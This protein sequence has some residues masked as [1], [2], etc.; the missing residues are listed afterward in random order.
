MRIDFEKAR[1]GMVRE[2]K[3]YVLVF[4]YL[5]LCIGAITVFKSLTLREYGIDYLPLGFAFF[6]ALILAKFIVTGHMLRLG[7]RLDHKPLIYST[8]YK[9]LIFFVLLLALS[10]AEEAIEGVLH[11][12]V[13]TQAVLGVGGGTLPGLL[14][15]SVIA[16]LILLPYIA[17]RQ[18][19]EVLGQG[20]LFYLFF[21]SGA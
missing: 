21:R 18:L 14:A 15:S 13:L 10:V 8:L 1:Q 19:D 16:L 3:E 5:Y 17:L 11:G 6:K 20:R 9:S 7:S 4:L 12:K 2:A